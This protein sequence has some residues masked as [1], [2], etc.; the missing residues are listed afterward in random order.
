MSHDLINISCDVQISR[1]NREK[2]LD[3]LIIIFI[4]LKL[5]KF[6]EVITMSKLIKIRCFVGRRSADQIRPFDQKKVH[7]PVPKPC[8]T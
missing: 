8:E 4:N 5:L 3:L 7:Q 1:N 6:M 2:C